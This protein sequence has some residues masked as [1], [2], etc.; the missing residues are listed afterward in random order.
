MD[1]SNRLPPLTAVVCVA[2]MG[3]AGGADAAASGAGTGAASPVVTLNCGGATISLTQ[4]DEPISLS[5]GAAT[6][7]LPARGKSPTSVKSPTAPSGST[8]SVAVATAAAVPAVARASAAADAPI[9]TLASADDPPA[10]ATTTQTDTKTTKT[11]KGGSGDGTSGA[12]ATTTTTTTT[13]NTS[14]TKSAKDGGGLS[15]S[16]FY[17]GAGFAISQN[18]GSSRASDVKFITRSDGQVLAQVQRSEDQNISAMFE[19]HYLLPG[20][21][22]FDDSP[23]YDKIARIAACG[24]F[25][26][27]SNPGA[28]RTGCGPLFTA[29]LDTDGKVSQFGIGWALGLGKQSDTSQRSSFGI[30]IGLL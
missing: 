29:I 27:V 16:D 6:L 18:I 24:P 7:T 25:S 14:T 22:I 13:S 5:C 15:A 2:T 12:T 11:A 19:T 9:I 20:Q 1:G 17:A 4:G 21:G 26:L 3:L 10:G 30:G 23:W 8:T 28:N